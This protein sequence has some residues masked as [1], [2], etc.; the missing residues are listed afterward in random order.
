MSDNIWNMMDDE[1]SHN[2]PYTHNTPQREKR[3]I[4]NKLNQRRRRKRLKLAAAGSFEEPV[5]NGHRHITDN[6]LQPKNTYQLRGRNV[7]PK[8]GHPPL[9][10]KRDR[11]YI[12]VACEG[13]VDKSQM[14]EMESTSEEGIRISDPSA[15]AAGSKRPC[16]PSKDLLCIKYG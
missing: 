8:C 14:V 1:I 9:S 15:L 10:Q 4:Q 5:P 13:S 16:Y 7:L 3:G 12:K 11:E 2:N 6:T